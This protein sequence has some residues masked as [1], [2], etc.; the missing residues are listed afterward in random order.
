MVV[1]QVLVGA[2]AAHPR[3]PQLPA[4]LQA[5]ARA[6]CRCPTRSS[7]NTSGPGVGAMRS[8]TSRRTPSSSARPTSTHLTWKN[9]LDGYSCTECGRCTAVCPAN[10]TGQTAERRAR[11]SSTRAQ[12][13][14]G[15][16]AR[17][18]GRPDGVPAARAAARRRRR[19]WRDDGG[20]VL[21]HRLLDKYITE[22]E[23][24][25]CTICRACVYECPVSI[26][27]LEIINELRR[28]LV[29]TESRFPE[30]VQPAFESM[31]RNGSPWAF[32][33]ADRA[34]TGPRARTSRRWRE[35][36]DARRA[37]RTCCSGSAAWARSTIAR[38]RSPSPSRASSR[39]ASVRFAILGQEESCH[40]DPA[41]RMGN[42][43]LYQM[44]AKQTIETLDRYGVQTIVTNCPHCFHQIGNEF[45]QLGGNYEV[46]HHS[47]YIERA[48]AG[49]SRSASTADEAARAHRRVSRLLLPRP[50]QRRVRRAARDDPKRALPVVTARGAAAQPRPRACAAARAAGACSWRSATGSASTSSARRSCSRPAPTRRRRLPVLHDDDQ[51]RG[52]G[53][54]G[55]RPG[56]G[57][58][59]AGGAPL[60][61][62]VEAAN[63]GNKSTKHRVF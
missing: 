51:R 29:L 46:I 14:D 39:R 42:E 22:E 57:H 21:E 59:G 7:S 31:E 24:W 9:L 8:W 63:S 16:G 11:S 1:G 53:I 18:H 61:H 62:I 25:A 37:A 5:P 28:N 52:E 27:Q 35:L 60:S 44:L 13:L 19:R 55:R 38:R 3:L 40:G 17:A 50:L 33:A 45:P 6:S 23:L 36:A 41:R 48:A 43:Y 34:A 26:D 20:A 2:R 15:D 49:G 12:R 32:Q 56:A 30:E 10:I 47:T 4:V 58:R 54:R